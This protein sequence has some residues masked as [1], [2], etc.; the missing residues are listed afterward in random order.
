V[1]LRQMRRSGSVSSQEMKLSVMCID[2][3][4]GRVVYHKDDLPGTTTPT[5][6]LRGDPQAHTV[7]ITLHSQ[8]ITLTYTHEAV[9]RQAAGAAPPAD[10]DVV[11]Q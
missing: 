1:L 3:R 5:C 9:D 8:Q 11:F 4:S 6:E 2:K 10:K 7:S